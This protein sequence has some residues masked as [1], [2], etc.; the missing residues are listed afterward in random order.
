MTELRVHPY[1]AAN[2]DLLNQYYSLLSS[3]PN[4]NWVTPDLAI[5]DTEA[6]DCSQRRLRTP[7]ALHSAT[8][9]RRGATAFLTNDAGL[10]RVT[11][12]EVDVLE[13]LR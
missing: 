1:R 2:E 7:N 8:A 3:F 9:I 13:H 4:L 6:Q 12:V 5:A 10:A 11:K